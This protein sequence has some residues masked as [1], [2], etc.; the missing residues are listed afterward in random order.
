MLIQKKLDFKG[1]PLRLG[2]NKPR[3][4]QILVERRKVVAKRGQIHR[5]D[6]C[7]CDVENLRRHN[8]SIHGHSDPFKCK[9]CGNNFANIARL[10]NHV[11]SK[12]S[13]G[14]KL[15][16]RRKDAG[17]FCTICGHSATSFDALRTHAT[18]H[19]AVAIPDE[20]TYAEKLSEAGFD[21]SKVKFGISKGKLPLS[22]GKGR[23]GG[24]RKTTSRKTI[25]RRKKTRNETFTPSDR[26]KYYSEK[27]KAESRLSNKGHV[28]VESPKIPGSIFDEQGNV[29][30]VQRNSKISEHKLSDS[31]NSRKKRFSQEI[32]FIGK[33]KKRHG[34]K[35]HWRIT[36]SGRRTWVTQHERGDR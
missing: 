6:F 20:R 23:R 33:K 18:I 9:V 27:R 35:G 2:N 3:K 10:I 15:R 12:H 7:D 22:K 26:D 21:T 30:S 4:Q 5:C 14:K 28:G 8:K 24:K 13:R 34:V 17:G 31:D 32:D 11:R 16:I 19:S 25:Q 1:G 29:K 36:P